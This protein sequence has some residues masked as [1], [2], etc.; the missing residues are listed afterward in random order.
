MVRVD[1]EITL[2]FFQSKEKPIQVFADVQKKPVVSKPV[3]HITSLI[4]TEHNN[5]KLSE[6]SDFDPSDRVKTVMCQET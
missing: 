5:N 1:S 3:S 4:P 2:R 6:K